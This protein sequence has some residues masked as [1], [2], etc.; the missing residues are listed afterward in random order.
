MRHTASCVAVTI[1]QASRAP[2]FDVFIV[3]R[4]VRRAGRNRG[5]GGDFWVPNTT[6]QLLLP[7]VRFLALRGAVLYLDVVLLALRARMLMFRSHAAQLARFAIF[8]VTRGLLLRAAHGRIISLRCGV[9]VRHAA[10]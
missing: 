8:L 4:S 3:E 1:A 2:V 7:P 9:V 6:N 5:V 10:M